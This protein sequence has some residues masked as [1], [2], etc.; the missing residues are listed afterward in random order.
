MVE[1]PQSPPTPPTGG[2]LLCERCG[3]PLDGYT[4]ET[5]CPE[6]ALPVRE[7]LPERRLGTAWQQRPSVRT[8]LMTAW[9]TVTRPR[10]VFH[11]L[12]LRADGPTR[13]LLWI[14]L[15]I[16]T[17][18]PA[19]MWIAFGRPWESGVRFWYMRS[20]GPGFSTGVASSMDAFS[21]PRTYL[22]IAIGLPVLLATYLLLTWI[23]TL[24]VRF[25]GQR[26]GWRVTAPI[27][28]SVCS[29]AAVGWVIGGVLHGASPG[30]V[31][32]ARPLMDLWPPATAVR[33]AAEA[34]MWAPIG[35]F[36]IGMLIFESLVYI[37][38]RECRY[39]NEPRRV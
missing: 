25:F 8:F 35:S 2:T 7:S 19:V 10:R 38:I 32:A 1:S 4:P 31:V 27:A 16:A 20:N 21:I 39:A 9:Q 12:Q 15:A 36:F 5:P 24:G 11:A 17:L 30:L 23:E 34:A 22:A 33:I 3:Y 6:C 18:A 28:W 13:R 29:H 26:R 14:Y 37:G